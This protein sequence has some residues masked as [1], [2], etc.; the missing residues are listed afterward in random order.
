MD[1]ELK[2]IGNKEEPGSEHRPDTIHLHPLPPSWHTG[3]QTLFSNKPKLS[4][5][6]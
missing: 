6:K 4:I 2:Q 5:V 3:P 1:A